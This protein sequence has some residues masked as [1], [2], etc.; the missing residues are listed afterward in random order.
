MQGFVSSRSDIPHRIEHDRWM[1]DKDDRDYL[2]APDR[3]CRVCGCLDS[4][5]VAIAHVR[6]PICYAVDEHSLSCPSRW[7]R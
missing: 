5:H 1:T 6:C 7:Y 4:D 3:W 2:K